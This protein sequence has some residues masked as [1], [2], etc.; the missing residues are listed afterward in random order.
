MKSYSIFALQ[1]D[2][3]KM[4]PGINIFYSNSSNQHSIRFMP[5]KNFWISPGGFDYI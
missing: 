2:K 3:N 4:K 1:L 5:K